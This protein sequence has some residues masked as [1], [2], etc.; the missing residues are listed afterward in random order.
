MATE[1]R[2]ERGV[3]T[4]VYAHFPKD[5]VDD[6]TLHQHVGDKLTDEALAELLA[7][8]HKANFV[9]K[10]AI[11][12]PGSAKKDDDKVRLLALLCLCHVE[13]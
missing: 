2:A 6:E 7:V 13:S 4:H 1:V 9:K 3:K 10:H 11:S 12:G 5:V 8:L